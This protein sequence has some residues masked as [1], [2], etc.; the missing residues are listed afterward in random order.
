MVLWRSHKSNLLPLVNKAKT[1][2]FGFPGYKPVLPGWFKICVL[3]PKGSPKWFYG[4]ARNRTCYPWFTWQKPTFLAFLGIHQFCAVDLRFVCWFYDGNTQ[5]SPK[6]V[7]WRSWESN[8]L[9][10]IPFTK[11]LFVAF[12]WVV[13][14]QY[15]LAFSLL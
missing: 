3:T 1:T 11:K 9:L 12:S 2:C 8:L 6:V 5:G 15:Y 10:L 7:L 14:N 4:G 13:S